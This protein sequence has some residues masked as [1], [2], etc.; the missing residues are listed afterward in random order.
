M[1]FSEADGE[2]V[3]LDCGADGRFGETAG[4]DGTDWGTRGEL[5][6][7]DFVSGWIA[8]GV[9]GAF[10]STAGPVAKFRAAGEDA[11][12][13]SELWLCGAAGKRIPQKPETGSVNSNST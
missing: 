12:V 11:T 1:G 8:A 5:G 2:F 4:L 10:D 6:I 7:A 13:V 3:E 9:T